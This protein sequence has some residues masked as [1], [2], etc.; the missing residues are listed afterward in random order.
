LEQGKP[1]NKGGVRSTPPLF[2]VIFR[3]LRKSYDNILWS[4]AE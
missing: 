2:S 4:Q 1:E 3:E